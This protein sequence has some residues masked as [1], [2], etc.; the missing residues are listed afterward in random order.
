MTVYENSYIMEPEYE[1]SF[2]P[3]RVTAAIER[4]V[5]NKLDGRVYN[6]AE[7]KQLSVELANEVKEAC[8]SLKMP[9]F[10]LCVQAL[11][12]EK[13]GQGIRVQSKC[14]W[15]HNLDNHA[16]CTYTKGN[17]TA[18]VVVFGLYFE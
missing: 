4:V 15:D 13:V 3:S 2:L 11:V 14:L 5:Q 18:C 12:A 9:R 1:E 6:D 10:K 7:G 8:K 17:I 16:T